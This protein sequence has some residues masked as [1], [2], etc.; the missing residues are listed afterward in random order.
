MDSTLD[1][2]GLLV[3]GLFFEDP[4]GE[5]HLRE[6]A[7]RA[8]VSASTAKRFLDEY[9]RS[10]LVTRTRK[11]NLRIFRANLEEPAF[12]L[13]KAS[14]LLL[15]SRPFLRRLAEEYSDS[16]LT[17]FGSCA[18]GTDGPGSDLDLLLITRRSA[19]PQERVLREFSKKVHRNIQM[20]RF[21][22]EQWERK[23]KEDRPFYERILIDG[24]P[25]IGSLP[26]VSP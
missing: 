17:L 13:W 18:N 8:E 2:P 25:V 12:R 4:Y 16:S 10:G 11:A 23:A 22:P 24:L 21:T 14:W 1:Y 3:L 26:V 15:K 19:E 20:I 6:V 7:S 9:T 5:L